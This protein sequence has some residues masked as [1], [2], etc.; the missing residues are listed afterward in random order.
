[1]KE[2]KPFSA[3]RLVKENIATEYRGSANLRAYVLA[4]LCDHDVLDSLFMLIA[5]RLNIDTQEGKN[6][7]VIG[8]LVGQPRGVINANGITFFG[9]APHPAANSFGTPLNPTIGGRFR[10]PGEALTG[11][12]T[13]IDSEYRKFIKAKIFRN[14]A[15]STPDEIIRFLKLL[16]GADTPI[17]LSNANPRPGHGR[18]LFGRALTLDERYLL[19]ETDLVPTTT[20]VTYHYVFPLAPSLVVNEISVVTD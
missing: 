12:K 17:F 20:G 13:L 14:H 8:E 6:L 7:D 11:N 18:I 3:A 2:L 10:A 5:D 1:M 4:L 15:R 9:F 19:M 16:L